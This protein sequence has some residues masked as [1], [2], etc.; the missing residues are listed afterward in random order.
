MSSQ[1]L[2]CPH[3]LAFLSNLVFLFV[4]ILC[5][6]VW[7][8]LV[9]S[10]DLI[11]YQCSTQIPLCEPS[12]PECSSWHLS[13]NSPDS[14]QSSGWPELRHLKRWWWWRGEKEREWLYILIQTWRASSTR[15]PSTSPPVLWT[16]SHQLSHWDP[17]NLRIN[18]YYLSC[19]SYPFRALTGLNYLLGMGLSTSGWGSPPE[20]GTAGCRTLSSSATRAQTYTAPP[21]R[22]WAVASQTHCAWRNALEI[23]FNRGGDGPVWFRCSRVL[24]LSLGCCI[25]RLWYL[26]VERFCV[27]VLA[28][29]PEGF[30][31]CLHESELKVDHHVQNG[32]WGIHT[33]T[34]TYIKTL[35]LY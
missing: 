9:V 13:T 21:G 14:W 35:Q 19:H 25:V 22:T 27:I 11:S 7:S 6:D 15:T 1:G 4:F 32:L 20:S 17:I 5:T 18:L 31:Q 8:T 10:N 26:Q 12:P 28:E 24:N 34:Y 2:D 23:R 16:I 30:P 29:P 33:N 3:L